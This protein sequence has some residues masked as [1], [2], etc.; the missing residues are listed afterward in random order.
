MK[1]FATLFLGLVFAG[2][3]LAIFEDGASAAREGKPKVFVARIDGEI[4]GRTADYV[5][6]V[7]SE[8]GEAQAEAVVIEIDTPGGDLNSTKEIV[9]AESN[10]EKTPI[11]TYVT[12]RGADAA[13][14]GAVI[15][16]ASDVAAMAPQS[17]IGATT[18]I[19]GLGRDLTGDRRQKVLNNTVSLITGLAAAHDRNEKWAEAAVREAASA[20]AAEALDMNV[21]EY[22][23]SDLRAV[24][25]AA[26]G[27]TV[28]S[29][30]ITLKTANATLVQQ[31]FNF[32]ERF[33]FST[34]WVIVPAVLLV[35][36]LTG[37]VFAV[38]RVSRVRV[39]TGREGMVGEIGT[40]RQTV[41]KDGGSVF[42]HGELWSAIPE[43]PEAAPIEKG[44]EVEIVDFRRTSIV[45][46]RA[47]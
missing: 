22:V 10:A 32:K 2:C 19:S 13:S 47:E 5:G 42:V 15:V 35:L 21:V 24:L 28:Q 20:N 36:F 31:P 12:P 39:S 41:D 25:K 14:A 34:W 38:Y 23:E 4:D 8:A 17:S 46:R 40:V 29:K 30:N 1:R 18:P 26:D 37:L 27:E 44:A 11:F 7:I 3:I 45:V 9:Q 6:R 16:M 33:G 43:D